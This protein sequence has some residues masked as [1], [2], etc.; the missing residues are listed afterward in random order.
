MSYFIFYIQIYTKGEYH[1][2]EI[3]DLTKK[4]H[5]HTVLDHLNM[6]VHKGDL[7]YIH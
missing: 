4:F 7:I 2:L 6:I 1:M 3:H 5:Q